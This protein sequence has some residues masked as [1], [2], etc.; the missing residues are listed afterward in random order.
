MESVDTS[1]SQKGT[2]L[3]KTDSEPVQIPKSED[4]RY[5]GAYREPGD[6]RIAQEKPR[7]MRK[8]A[9]ITYGGAIDPARLSRD[10]GVPQGLLKQILCLDVPHPTG[11]TVL[12]FKR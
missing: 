8:M 9:E 11:A 12:Q 4:E 2:T 6:E 1:T 5:L 10:S 7:L 3:G